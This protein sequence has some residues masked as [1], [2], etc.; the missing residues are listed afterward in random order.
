[1]VEGFDE[2]IANTRFIKGGNEMNSLTSIPNI[3]EVLAQKL[4]DVGINSPENLIEVGSKEAF[5]RIKHAD[6][7]ACINM[8]YALEGAIQGV[9]WHSLSDETK[10]E[11]KQFFK[12][13]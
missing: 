2:L 8:L 9:R 4:I 6:D 3:G 10:R 5:I 12:A 7:S 11:L 1:M 13:L